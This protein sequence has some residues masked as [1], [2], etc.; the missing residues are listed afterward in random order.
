MAFGNMIFPAGIEAVDSWQG[1]EEASMA[2]D[3][4]GS[5]QGNFIK[6][7][8]QRQGY[9]HHQGHHRE[10]R[11][12]PRYL[13]RQQLKPAPES[14]EL[15]VPRIHLQGRS[16]TLEVGSG[17][18]I[19]V[20]GE[21]EAGVFP[22]VTIKVQQ[23]EKQLGGALVSSREVVEDSRMLVGGEGR[24]EVEVQLLRL[25]K[26]GLLHRSIRSGSGRRILKAPLSQVGNLRTNL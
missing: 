11:C 6:A 12:P 10:I 2:E 15:R 7:A 26:G 16:D 18:G 5:R 4:P 13:P 20:G 19:E 1:E 3:N 14:K 8:A 21:G 23:R 24:I 9:C 25:L 17:E 22:G